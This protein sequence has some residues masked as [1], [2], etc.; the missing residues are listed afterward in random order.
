M[1]AALPVITPR[2]RI[3]GGCCTPGVVPA[4]DEGRADELA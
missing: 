1:E 2:E 4:L 3:A